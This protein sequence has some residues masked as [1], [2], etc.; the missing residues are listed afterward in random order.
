MIRKV[1]FY[2]A[3]ML[4][5]I[6]FTQHSAAQKNDVYLFSY[7]KGNGEDGLH[8]AYSN[9]GLKWTSLKDETP[10]PPQK[11]IRVAFSDSLTGPYSKPSKPITGNYWAE[12]PTSMKIGDYWY[13]YFDKYRDKKYGAVR[14]KNLQN[15]EDV[16]DQIFFLTE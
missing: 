13:V 12:G 10:D 7:F 6:C 8:L 2:F 14:S 3:L 16:S 4:S 15:W 9:D 11:N 1:N 5:L